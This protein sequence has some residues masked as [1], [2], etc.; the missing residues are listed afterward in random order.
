MAGM[1]CLG[2]LGR[3]REWVDG[4]RKGS[5]P[6]CRIGFGGVGSFSAS[7]TSGWSISS[8]CC[9]SA[10]TLS[11]ACCSSASI[12]STIEVEPIPSVD[13]DII[14]LPFTESVS[15]DPFFRSFV[16]ISANV[17]CEKTANTDEMP[18]TVATGSQVHRV[19]NRHRQGPK[20]TV[21]V[22]SSWSSLVE[23]FDSH[24][25]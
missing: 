12:T 4:D 3:G 22:S 14:S 20:R 25:R 24:R 5:V 21:R 11:L 8:C 9:S 2:G 16:M 23:H 15:L 10:S 18:L 1:D 17:N 19:R 13:T 7:A 6:E